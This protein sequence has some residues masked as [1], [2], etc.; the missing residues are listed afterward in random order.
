MIGKTSDLSGIT[1]S[2]AVAASAAFPILFAPLCF[3]TVGKVFHDT[4]GESAY[5]TIPETL[6]LADG[7]VYDNLGSES[8]LRSGECFIV[9]DGSAKETPWAKDFRPW[10]LQKI[11]RNLVVSMEQ[12][13]LLRRRLIYKNDKTIQLLIDRPL[14]EIREKDLRANENLKNL[15]DYRIE[16]DAEIAGLIGGPAD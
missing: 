9:V 2:F 3:N 12:I 5:S 1:V 4:Y 15:P 11:W 14:A 16:H 13:V 6:F 7:G 10:F 8:S